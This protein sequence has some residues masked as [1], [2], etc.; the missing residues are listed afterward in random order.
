VITTDGR[1]GRWALFDP[2]GR[3]YTVVIGA[4]RWTLKLVPGRGLM[5]IHDQSIVVFQAVKPH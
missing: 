2:D 5:D 4:D 3:V 1:R